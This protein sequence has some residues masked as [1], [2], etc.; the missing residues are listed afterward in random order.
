MA[1]DK[2]NQD[3]SQTPEEVEETPGEMNEDALDQVSGGMQQ[4]G[5]NYAA[6]IFAKVGGNLV[7]GDGIKK[8]QVNDISVK[9]R[10]IQP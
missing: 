10:K 4:T 9:Q 3:K 8:N 6:D 7:N 1:D 5:A 2:L